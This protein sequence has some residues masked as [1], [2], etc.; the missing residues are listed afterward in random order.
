VR[1]H[2]VSLFED[3]VRRWVV[4]VAAVAPSRL[5]RGLVLAIQWVAPSPC[6]SKAF[7]RYADAEEWLLVVLRRARLWPPTDDAPIAG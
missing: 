5:L 2:H 6:P 1:E 3:D 7:D 4:A